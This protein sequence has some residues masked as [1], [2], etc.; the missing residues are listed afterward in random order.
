MHRGYSRLTDWSYEIQFFMVEC[1]VYA[2][3]IVHHHHSLH[4]KCWCKSSSLHSSAN[5]SCL[6]FYSHTYI[7]IK[8]CSTWSWPIVNIACN[9]NSIQWS[10]FLARASV[11]VHVPVTHSHPSFSYNVN[12]DLITCWLQRS[13]YNFYRTLTFEQRCAHTW[14]SYGTTMRSPTSK[15]G[16]ILGAAIF[17]FLLALVDAEESDSHVCWCACVFHTA[18]AQPPRTVTREWHNV[19]LEK[20]FENC[21][22]RREQQT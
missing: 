22:K 6:I 21:K 18:P 2:P 20:F 5:N 17:I 1:I 8:C 4:Q 14:R 13:F 3:F 9:K 10:L 16:H 15:V 11:S 19:W 12:Y 7:T